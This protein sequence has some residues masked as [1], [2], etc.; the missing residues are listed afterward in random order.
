[1]I[2][3]PEENEKALAKL[4]DLIEDYDVN[5]SEIDVLW[6]EIEKYEE[7][8]PEFAE[9]NKRINEIGDSLPKV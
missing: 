1:M 9:F 6:V 3:S 2:K 8:A 4:S 7:T 5:K